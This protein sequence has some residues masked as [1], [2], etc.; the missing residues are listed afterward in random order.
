M[1]TATVEAPSRRLSW[2]RKQSA[3]RGGGTPV[4]W[5]EW[6]ALTLDS[7]IIG[8]DIDRTHI[9]T[10]IHTLWTNARLSRPLECMQLSQQTCFGGQ[11]VISQLICVWSNT[12]E[13]IQRKIRRCARLTVG[14]RPLVF[15]ISILIEVAVRQTAGALSGGR[16]CEREIAH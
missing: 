11:I 15:K 5:N 4:E 10:Y 7:N 13:R 16:Q 12:V 9:H 8:A 1:L 14:D 2:L 6:E 3:R